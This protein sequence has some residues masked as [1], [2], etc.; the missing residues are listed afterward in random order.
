MGSIERRL[1]H[2]ETIKQLILDKAQSIAVNEGWNAVTIRRL[3]DEI[4]YTLPVIYTH[5][6]SKEEIITEIAKLG[7]L[8][9]EKTLGSSF[10]D[11]V[12]PRVNGLNLALAYCQFAADNQALYQAM[13]GPD[14]I[15]S[16]YKGNPEEGEQIFFLVKYNLDKLI[17][18]GAKIKDS[19]QTTKL[20]W[21]T[22]HGLVSLDFIGRIT[23]TTTNQQEII[24]DFI[25]LLYNSWG[26]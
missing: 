6:K 1:K 17:A 2:K 23:D 22:L 9:L 7:F 24:T 16:F 19:W 3:A 20:I 4:E 18:N 11:K 14:G 8:K 25:N 21:S 26:L 10:N 15:S 13:Y 5:F 12:A